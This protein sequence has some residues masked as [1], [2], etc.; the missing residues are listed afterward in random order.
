MRGD[1]GDSG[2]VKRG[3]LTFTSAVVKRAVVDDIKQVP[4]DGS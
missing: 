4:A 1:G 2:V 3:T